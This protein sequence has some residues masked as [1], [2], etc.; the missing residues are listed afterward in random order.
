MG[1]GGGGGQGYFVL[2]I[3]DMTCYENLEVLTKLFELVLL[4]F[5][6]FSFPGWQ[7][8]D[9]GPRSLEEMINL[10]SRCKVIIGS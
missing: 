2:D 4:S 8:V 7:P 5:P 6:S 3:C 9:I 10:L 1:G